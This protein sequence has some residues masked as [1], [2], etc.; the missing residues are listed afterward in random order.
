M[1]DELSDY[2][3][4]LIL[5]TLYLDKDRITAGWR[6]NDVSDVQARTDAIS[7]NQQMQQVEERIPELKGLTPRMEFNEPAQAVN[8]VTQE[9]ISEISARLYDAI[10]T[11]HSVQNKGYDIGVADSTFGY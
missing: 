8:G 1:A 4:D 5:A 11:V 7:W 9:Q 6:E 2:A 3:K 10:E